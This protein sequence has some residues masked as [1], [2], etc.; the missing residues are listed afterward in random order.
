MKMGKQIGILT[1]LI[2][3]LTMSLSLAFAAQAPA[4]EKVRVLCFGDSNTYGWIPI[5]QGTPTTRYAS[6]VRWTG[7]LQKELGDNYKIIEEGLNGRT[8]GLDEY[9]NGL[10]DSITKDLNLNGRPHLLPIL[11]SQT[12]LD[13]VVIMLGT[14]DTKYYFEQTPAQIAQSVKNLVEIVQKSSMKKET[15]WLTYRAPKVL[16][17]APV[18]VQQGAS[19]GLNTLF[20]EQSDK[21]SRQLAPLYAQVAKETGAE[22]FDAATLVP[23]ADGVDGIHLS[24]EAH[25]KMGKALAEKIRNMVGK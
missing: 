6:D 10:D 12:P 15:E 11:K 16:V 2:F 17:V 25:N 13:V 22:F 3:M 20:T 19:E 7:V 9:A 21:V 4:A 24:P 18:P 8:A 14:N 23:V 1:L 5:A